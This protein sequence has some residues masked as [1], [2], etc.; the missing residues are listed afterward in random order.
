VL[1]WIGDNNAIGIITNI[2]SWV[3][4]MAQTCAMALIGAVIGFYTNRLLKRLHK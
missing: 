2:P 1:G 3:F 4:D